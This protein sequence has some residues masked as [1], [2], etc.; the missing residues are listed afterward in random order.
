[1]LEVVKLSASEWA[2][3]CE[4]TMSYSFKDEHWPR[5]KTRAS[6]ALVVQNSETKVPY[7]FST[8]I[9]FDS[10]SVYMQHGG[11]FLPADG[12]ALVGRGYGL[13]VSWLV[14]NY[15]YISTRIWN[16]NSA[17]LKLAAKAGF[18]ITGM[19]V[20]EFGNLFLFH[21]IQTVTND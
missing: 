3:I 9:E 10:E 7:C 11:S 6:F 19:Q 20:N 8:L 12:T 18:V 15:K 14:E 1:M 17:M 5:E 13:M 16:K 2:D 21:E 4:T